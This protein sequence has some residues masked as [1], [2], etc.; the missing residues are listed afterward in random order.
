MAPINKTVIKAISILSL[1]FLSVIISYINKDK[2]SELSNE[3]IKE[4]ANKS[5]YLI[6]DTVSFD[7]KKP[8]TL[9][10]VNRND[11]VGT[12]IGTMKNNKEEFVE[13]L[14]I[15]RNPETPVQTLGVRE[16][17]SNPYLVF[18]IN[19]LNLLQ[20]ASELKVNFKDGSVEKI[21]VKN[22]Q[23]I[24]FLLKEQK[25]ALSDFLIYDNQNSIIYENIL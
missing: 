14:L 17:A 16:G 21:P 19:D 24:Y 8:Y 12:F 13:E 3:S 18:V 7:G 22:N 9:I 1:I 10:F 25:Q 4:W 15:Q 20:Q 11:Q 6:I 2:Y 23:S 5:G